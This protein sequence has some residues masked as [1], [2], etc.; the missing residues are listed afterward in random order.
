VK[1]KRNIPP[2]WTAEVGAAVAVVETIGLVVMEVVGAAVEV[3]VDAG[4][5]DVVE[6]QPITSRAQ[7]NRNATGRINL[8]PFIMP[9]LFLSILKIF[10]RKY[11]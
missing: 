11:H 5:D 4:A 2:V 9:P 8:T 10:G 3:V 7:I 1:A 6:L